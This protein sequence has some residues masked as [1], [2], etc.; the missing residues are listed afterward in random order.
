MG[1][2]SN[3][4]AQAGLAANKQ[5]TLCSHWRA[6]PRGE[7]QS[8]LQ[9]CVDNVFEEFLPPALVGGCVAFF[10]HVFFERRKAL[11]ARVDARAHAARPRAVS[12]GEHL[13]EDA[14]AANRGGDF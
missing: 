14:V 1:L 11:L 12:L 3:S 8:K 13:V 2:P 6:R 9:I 10:E 7:C 5:G 4:A